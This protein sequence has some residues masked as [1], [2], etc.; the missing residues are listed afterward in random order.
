MTTYLL[1]DIFL[2]VQGEGV[3]A[4][5]PACFVRLQGCA[6]GCPW[7]DT[8]ETWVADP[9][10]E[11]RTTLG[12]LAK[13]AYWAKA[14]AFEIAMLARTKAPGVRWAIVTG[15][16]P[17]EQE[18]GELVSA[19]HHLHFKAAVETSGTAPGF[20]GAGFDWVTLSPKIGMPGGK[21]ILP[22][23]VLAADEIKFV[24]GKPADIVT[25][26]RFLASYPTKGE[27]TICLQ[28]V[29]LSKAATD[30]CLSIVKERGWRL[31]LQTH[32]LIGQP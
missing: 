16:E 13:D 11:A 14:T 24:V 15:G 30:L 32:R 18:L 22:E 12:A 28:P 5:V 1:N 2:S 3:H 9:A 21:A 27:P 8:K 20:L 26:D 4:G 17:A 31:S 19:L 7:C 29:S 6:V 25:V 10:L 23:A